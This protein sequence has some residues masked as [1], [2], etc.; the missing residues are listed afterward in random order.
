MHAPLPS[1]AA[2]TP[3]RETKGVAM[4]KRSE[5]IAMT[6]LSLGAVPKYMCGCILLPRALSP[7]IPHYVFQAPPPPPRVF[8]MLIL[9]PPS[10]AADVK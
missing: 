4:N 2:V 3:P 8:Y 6:V 9:L 10:A 1:P 7:E 5:F